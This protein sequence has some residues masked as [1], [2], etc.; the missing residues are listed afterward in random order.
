LSAAQVSVKVLAASNRLPIPQDD[1]AATRKNV[2]TT[3]PVD[4]LANDTDPDR[5]PLVVRGLRSKP[6]N[7]T[8]QVNFGTWT[9]TYTPNFNITGDDHLEYIVTDMNSG[10]VPATVAVTVNP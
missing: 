10:D 8:A 9:I 6:R 7:G 3:P 1:T 4:V 5:D 2:A